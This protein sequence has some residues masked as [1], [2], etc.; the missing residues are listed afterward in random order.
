MSTSYLVINQ[1]FILSTLFLL[2]ASQWY[3]INIF[4]RSGRGRMSRNIFMTI[5]NHPESNVLGML[6]LTL[7]GQQESSLGCG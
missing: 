1:S 2:K 5:S 3:I 7:A 6:M 4:K